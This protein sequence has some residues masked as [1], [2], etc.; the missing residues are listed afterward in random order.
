MQDSPQKARKQLGF[1]CAVELY[2]RDSFEVLHCPNILPTDL[3]KRMLEKHGFGRMY[4]LGQMH[5][6]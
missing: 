4:I 2:V 1:D 5:T 3:R 6:F